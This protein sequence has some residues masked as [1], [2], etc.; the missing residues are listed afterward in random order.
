MLKSNENIRQSPSQGRIKCN[1]P[2]YLHGKKGE[3]GRGRKI[4][5]GREKIE[6]EGK[7][8]SGLNKNT[9]RYEYFLRNVTLKSPEIG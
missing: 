4:I 3:E 7:K 5:S 2:T 6:G 9:E 1:L 8:Q